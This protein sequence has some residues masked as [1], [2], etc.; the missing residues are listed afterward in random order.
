MFTHIPAPE[1]AFGTSAI[2]RSNAQAKRAT[3]YAI[4]VAAGVALFGAFAPVGSAPASAQ[5]ISHDGSA[6]PRYYDSE[7]GQH[8]GS[9][10]PPTTTQKPALFDVKPTPQPVKPLRKFR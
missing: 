1:S 9:W 5:A 10:G 6:L 2:G 3:R 8:W 7:G 4:A